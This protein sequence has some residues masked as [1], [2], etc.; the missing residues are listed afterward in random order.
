MGIGEKRFRADAGTR[1]S[2]KDPPS[3]AVVGDL[4]EETALLGGS[5][6]ERR[7]PASA[8][9]KFFSNPRDSTRSSPVG[10]MILLLL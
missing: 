7:V 2:M 9:K 8:R 1:R 5:F 3:R 6:M 4:D 10:D